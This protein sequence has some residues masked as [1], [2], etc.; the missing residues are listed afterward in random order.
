MWLLRLLPLLSLCALVVA[1]SPVA[2]ASPSGTSA[3][4]VNGVRLSPAQRGRLGRLIGTRIP[5]GRYWYDRR[6][7]LYGEMG[8]P[9]LG[10]LRPGLPVP[11]ELSARASR[12]RAGRATGIFWNGREVH[13]KEAA[14]W[15]TLVG[16][17]ARGRF[18]LAPNGTFGQVG[19]PPLG[20]LGQL[21]AMRA[22]ALAAARRRPG[23]P[24][25]PRSSGDGYFQGRAR[26]G[27]MP[28]VSGTIDRSGGGNHVIS[29]D[30]EVL[31]LP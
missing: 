2:R 29:V 1:S 21:Y 28:L 19:G 8:G 15:A 17:A 3:V 26:V 30:G 24:N 13:P 25:G 9:A 22:S 5:P 12:G 10:Q 14:L 23:R 6:S 7:G 27:G 11:G 20:N 16:P 18:W 4:R 31:T